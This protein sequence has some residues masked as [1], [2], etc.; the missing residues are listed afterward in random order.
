MTGTVRLTMAQALVRFLAASMSSGTASS[1]VLRGRVGDLRPRERGGNRSGAPP[2]R[3]GWASA[4]A[5]AQRAGAGARRRR[6]RAHEERLRT[7]ACTSSVGPGATNMVTGAAAATINRLPVLILPGD[8]FASRR[9]DPVLQQLESPATQAISVNDAFRCVSRYWD[10]IQRPEQIIASAPEAMRV[11]TDPADTGAVTLALPQDVQAEAFDYPESFFRKRR[12]RIG[13]RCPTQAIAEAVA[14]IR[15]ASTAD[16]R[17]RGVIYRGDRG[18]A[19]ARRGRGSRR[20]D[21][22]G[23][24]PPFDH[25]ASLGALGVTGTP[26]ANLLARDADLVIGVGTRWSD[27]STASRTAFQHPDVSFVNLNVAR[28]DA[29]KLSGVPLVGDARDHRRAGPTR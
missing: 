27:F 22:G 29:H 1:S 13:V 10:R 25:P 28:F 7:W 18:F 11:L 17:R 12:W 26:G 15:G 19:R 5:R 21:D 8:T 3:R 23:G 16:R 24:A 9:P 14:R 6:I 2:A 4:R 20:R